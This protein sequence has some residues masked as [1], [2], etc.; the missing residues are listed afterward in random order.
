MVWGWATM[1][2]QISKLGVGV[3]PIAST[4]EIAGIIAA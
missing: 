2:R 4:V 1:V 3:V